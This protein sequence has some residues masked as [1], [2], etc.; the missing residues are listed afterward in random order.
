M[1]D[2]PKNLI[3]DNFCRKEFPPWLYQVTRYNLTHIGKTHFPWDAIIN[4]RDWYYWIN[5]HGN[6]FRSRGKM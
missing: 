1:R 2:Y 6:K 3:L 4:Y 5:L